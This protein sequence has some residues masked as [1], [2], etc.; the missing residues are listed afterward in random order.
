MDKTS[1]MEYAR[2][3][4][5]HMNVIC[6]KTDE[7]DMEIPKDVKNYFEHRRKDGTDIWFYMYSEGV[8]H[9]DPAYFR[10]QPYK[11]FTAGASGSGFWSFADIGSANTSW[12]PYLMPSGYNYSPVYISPDSITTAKQFEAI[13]EGIEDFYY[14]LTLKASG[15]EDYSFN[16]AT[17]VLTRAVR[18]GGNNYWKTWQNNYSACTAGEKMR[19]EILNRLE[20]KSAK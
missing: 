8:R 3:A 20:K 7:Y 18:K 11:A 2:E 14:L 17:S 16:L 12:N 10:L 15:E 1:Y 13:R 19:L 5:D 9:F 6:V 4:L